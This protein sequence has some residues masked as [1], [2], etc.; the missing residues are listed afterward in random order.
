[1]ID[2]GF[3]NLDAY[4]ENLA[5]AFDATPL[6]VNIDSALIRTNI[7]VEFIFGQLGCFPI[8]LREL[9]SA[10]KRGIP[11]F[12]DHVLTTT[13]TNVSFLPLDPDAMAGAPFGTPGLPRFRS[14]AALRA[15]CCTAD[16]PERKPSV[17]EERR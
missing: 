12:K 11:A 13:L 6:V 7:F 16:R 10:L 3:A 15:S 9:L 4:S 5:D 8:H 17:F 14:W 2:A 1:M